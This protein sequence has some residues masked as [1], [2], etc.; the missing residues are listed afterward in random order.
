MQVAGFQAAAVQ[1]GIR[2][3]GRLDLGLIVAEGPATVAGVFTTNLVKAAPVL[4]GQERVAKGQAQAILVNSGCA[5]ACTG[6]AGMAAARAAAAA[7]ARSL[8]IAEE[9]VLPC[10]TGVIGEPLPVER[11]EAA[12]PDLVRDLAADGLPAVARAMM[13]TDTRP[14]TASRTGLVA[15]RPVTVAG[16]AKGAGMIMPNMATMLSFLLT[17]AALEATALQ[18]ALRQAVAESFNAITIDGDTSTNDTVLLLASGRAGHPPLTPADRDG[19][20]AFTA[21]LSDLCQDLAGQIVA[22][23]EGVTKEVT[24]RVRGARTRQEAEQAGRTIA[25][26]ALVK[27]AF[28]GA[29][30]NWGRILAAAGRSGAWLDPRRVAIAIDGVL[31]VR[32]GLAVGQEAEAAAT[33]IL[34]GRSFTVTVDLGAG[35]AEFAIRTC[36]LSIDYVKINADY[37]S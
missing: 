17:D 26:S 14:K 3:Q 32:D 36:D 12:V 9:L 5:N 7:V 1:A 33:A 23:G 10:S 37:R 29:D 18:E 24:I 13:T 2:Y 4:L 28:F 22:D 35:P 20:A 15:G 31:L 27:T 11:I 19:P 25:N 16:L 34:K 6:T 21:L 8:G 30:A